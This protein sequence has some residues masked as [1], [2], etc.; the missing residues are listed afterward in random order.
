MWFRSQC[1]SIHE[2]FQSIFAGYKVNRIAALMRAQFTGYIHL[3]VMEFRAYYYSLQVGFVSSPPTVSTYK[4]NLGSAQ[5]LEDWQ[6]WLHH[7]GAARAA[8]LH[9]GKCGTT[10]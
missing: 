1:Y 2:K 9:S 4:Q 3:D 7:H 6:P 5:L 8:S 10:Q